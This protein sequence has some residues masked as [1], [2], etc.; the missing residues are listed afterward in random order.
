MLLLLLWLWLLLL[1]GAHQ[2]HGGR[3]RGRVHD[4][5]GLLHKLLLWLRLRLWLLGQGLGRH[6]GR[7]ARRRL[8]HRILRHVL[9]PRHRSKRCARLDGCSRWRWRRQLLRRLLR[10]LDVLLAHRL[11]GGGCWHGQHRY[12]EVDVQWRAQG[13]LGEGPGKTY[14]RKHGEHERA[15]MGRGEGCYRHH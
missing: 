2:H 12:R 13:L 1:C 6:D 5:R 10:M 15:K 4:L 7:R 9:L 8:L 11:G 14:I 3:L